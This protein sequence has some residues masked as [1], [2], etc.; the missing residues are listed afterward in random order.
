[1]IWP[2]IAQEHL[3]ANSTF[4]KM[5]AQVHISRLHAW[6]VTKANKSDNTSVS[7]TFDS[8]QSFYFYIGFAPMQSLF[9]TN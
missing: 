7:C 5:K 3:H 4:A 9:K 2:K 6:K 1:M 8:M